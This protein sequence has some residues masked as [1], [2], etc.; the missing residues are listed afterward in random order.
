MTIGVIVGGGEY[1]KLSIFKKND[2][3]PYSAGNGAVVSVKPCGFIVKEDG[4]Y[5]V[6]TVSENSYEKII[7]KASEF[8]ES[9]NAEN[10]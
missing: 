10:N 7:D 5:K 4:K 1:G 3:L 2:D 9:F 6:L 8:L